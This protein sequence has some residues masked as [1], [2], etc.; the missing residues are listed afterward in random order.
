M[1]FTTYDERLK[2]FRALNRMMIINEIPS[3]DRYF[4]Q[5]RCC[6]IERQPMRPP[7]IVE[8]NL[9]FVME[10]GRNSLRQMLKLNRNYDDFELLVI[11]R[12]LLE[13]GY[14]LE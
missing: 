14:L 9:V 7:K 8:Y 13:G 11:L 1:K 12:Q 6:F 4:S 5:L 2:A 10:F 3:R